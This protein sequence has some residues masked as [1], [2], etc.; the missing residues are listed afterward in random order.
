MRKTFLAIGFAAAIA[1]LAVAGDVTVQYLGHSCFTI[2]QEAGEVIMIDPYGSLVAYPGLPKAAD[3][4]LVTH[5]HI[6]HNPWE[7]GETGRVLGD[8]IIV[9]LLDGSGRCREKRLPGSWVITPTFSTQAIEGNH[10][11]LSGGGQ[12]YV[13]MFSFEVD[14]IR[15]AHLGDLGRPLD[16]S[17]IEG[18]AD[19]DV[20]FVPVGGAFTLDAAEAL[21]VIRQLP[22]VRIAIPMHYFVQGR[23][24]DFWGEMASIDAFLDVVEDEL[25]VRRMG[26]S[27]VA[28]RAETLPE[29]PEVWVLPYEE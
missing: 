7:Y 29:T 25:V 24:P 3:I 9:H 15:F 28:I 5:D 26:E 14:G 16:A 12:G 8:P 1:V 27:R 19:V 23:T 4:V 20:L 2:Q 21:E 11:T 18:L 6:D 10:V 17:Q 13:C 22:T